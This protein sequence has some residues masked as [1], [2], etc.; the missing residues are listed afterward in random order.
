MNPYKCPDHSITEIYS[1]CMGCME[2]W[3]KRYNELAHFVRRTSHAACC[4]VC[5]CL[6]CEAR[7][8][9]QRIGIEHE[10]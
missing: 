6:V 8:I 3:A 10:E 7:E 2:A 4:T 1:Q 9:L 5:D